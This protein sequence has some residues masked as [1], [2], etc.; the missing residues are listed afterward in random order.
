MNFIQ[1]HHYLKYNSSCQKPGLF[2]RIIIIEE[3]WYVDKFKR[4]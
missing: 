1:L 2:L 3:M 4:L